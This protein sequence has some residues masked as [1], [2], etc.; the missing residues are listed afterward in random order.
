[1][2]IMW[3]FVTAINRIRCTVIAAEIC[4]Q[5]EDGGGGGAAAAAADNDDDNNNNNNN[6]TKC[7]EDQFVNIKKQESNQLNM[8]STIKT[9][10]K[11]V[12]E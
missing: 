11:V 7:T 4:M 12:Q 2:A 5:V 9:T 6:N 8:N 10:E 3:L 1:M